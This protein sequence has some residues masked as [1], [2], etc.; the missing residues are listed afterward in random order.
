MAKTKNFFSLHPTLLPLSVILLAFMFLIMLVGSGLV[1]RQVRF[2][3]RGAGVE[4]VDQTNSLIFADPLSVGSGKTPVLVKVFLRDKNALAVSGVDV[5]LT[6]VKGTIAPSEGGNIQATTNENGMVVFSV[7]LPE[8][9]QT[10]I[11][12]V[13]GPQETPLSKNITI[14]I[15]SL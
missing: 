8:L 11:G 2:L 13:F 4:S 1:S 7:I 5:K 9:T 12:V 3:S 15:V 14:Q 6:S 10:T